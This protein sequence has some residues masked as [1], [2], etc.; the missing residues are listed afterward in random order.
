MY[1]TGVS[2]VGKRDPPELPNIF[3]GNGVAVASM[4]ADL[5]QHQHRPVVA[6]LGGVAPTGVLMWASPMCVGLVH[7]CPLPIGRGHVV[8][9]ELKSPSAFHGPLSSVR[10]NMTTVS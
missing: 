5:H 7:A 8:S 4:C 6:M 2:P 1:P 9:S 3:S 10:V